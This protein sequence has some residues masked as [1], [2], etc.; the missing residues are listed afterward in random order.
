VDKSQIFNKIEDENLIA[1]AFGYYFDKNGNMKMQSNSVGITLKIFEKINNSI[2]VAAGA[3][4]AEA[5]CAISKFNNNFILVTDEA[6]AI[7]ILKI[8]E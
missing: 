8:S 3:S 1:E 7:N 2:A 5:I 6:T 4:K